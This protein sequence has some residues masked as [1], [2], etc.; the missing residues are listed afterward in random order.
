MNIAVIVSTYNRP[1]ALKKVLDGLLNQTRC[2]EE[3]IIADD[4]SNNDT[5]EMLNPYLEKNDILIHHVWHEDDGFRL[6]EIRNKAILKSSSKYLIF[7]DG[8]CIPSRHFIADHFFLAQKGFFFQGKRVIVSKEGSHDFSFKD[9]TSLFCL[10]QHV[11]ASRVSNS[12]HIFRLP[13]FPSYTTSKL[14]GVRGC[15]MGFFKDDLLSVNGFNQEFKGWGR[16][17][18][19]IVVRLYKYG[20]KR[21]EHPFRAICY[22]L[23]HKENTRIAIDQN[24]ELLEQAMASDAYFCNAGIKTMNL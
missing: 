16:E 12:H 4:G 23:W 15:N 11:F 10:L 1:D 9:T 21:K 8:D 14:S 22:H 6:A 5:R 17:D 3:I 20:I 19:E 2:P 18:S 7:L 13:F 24:D